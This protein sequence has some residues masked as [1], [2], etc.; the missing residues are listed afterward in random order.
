MHLTLVGCNITLPMGLQCNKCFTINVYMYIHINCMYIYTYITEG[1]INR[2]TRNIFLWLT[3]T[4]MQD[5]GWLKSQAVNTQ[6]WHKCTWNW[7][8]VVYKCRLHETEIGLKGLAHKPLML[9]LQEV[10]VV[11]VIL[12]VKICTGPGLPYKLQNEKVKIF[13]T[14]TI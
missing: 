8:Q 13:K 1:R 7:E 14:N 12:Q 9:P 2:R 6:C 3:N 11:H 4:M 5:F 10:W